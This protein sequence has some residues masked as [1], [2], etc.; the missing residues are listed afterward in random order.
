MT[1]TIEYI[2]YGV[3]STSSFIDY[4]PSI[5]SATSAALSAGIAAWA[6][7]FS[8][9][10]IKILEEHNRIMVKPKIEG[11]NI[12]NIH[13]ETLKYK[14]ANTGLGPATINSVEI[15]ENDTKITSTDLIHAAIKKALPWISEEEF[16]HMS[17]QPG[18]TLPAG[19]SE[20]LFEIQ[21]D[22]EHTA[23]KIL[24]SFRPYRIIIHYECAY[25]GSFRFESGPEP[26]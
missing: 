6:L 20:F 18:L 21:G 11:L 3:P 4:L 8:S 14:L 13:K 15:F 19:F 10:Q 26:S 24:E 5:L 9:K 1:S 12:I 7:R 2:I 22:S 16:G 25:G 23:T 17:I